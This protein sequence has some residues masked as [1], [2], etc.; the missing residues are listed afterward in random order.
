MHAKLVKICQLVLQILC[1]VMSTSTGAAPKTTCPR[2]FPWE[3]IMNRMEAL[4]RLRASNK[5]LARLCGRSTCSTESS[6]VIYAKSAVQSFYNTMF[7]V[8]RNLSFA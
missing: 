3:V 4:I 8:H 2:P 1:I 5:S 6:Q 7:G